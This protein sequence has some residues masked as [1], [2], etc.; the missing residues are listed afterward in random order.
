M[1]S[2]LTIFTCGAMEIGTGKGDPYQSSFVGGYNG[3][4][5]AGWGTHNVGV[6]TIDA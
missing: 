4:H 5:A 2:F 6:E 1:K 3:M